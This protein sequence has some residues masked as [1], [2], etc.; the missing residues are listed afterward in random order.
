MFGAYYS[1]FQLQKGSKTL[2]PNQMLTGSVYRIMRHPIVFCQV[3]ILWL[4]PIMTKQR[5]II[6]TICTLI[7]YSI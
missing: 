1:L 7:G 2:F 4:T 3:C 6:W 5:L